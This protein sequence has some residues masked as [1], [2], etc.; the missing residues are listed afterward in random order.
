MTLP[1]LIFLTR[2]LLV[3]VLEVPSYASSEV[4][5]IGWDWLV[6]WIV[7]SSAIVYTWSLIEYSLVQTMHNL[8]T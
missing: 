7:V 2:T 8:H 5:A 1:K 6:A 4:K 3:R